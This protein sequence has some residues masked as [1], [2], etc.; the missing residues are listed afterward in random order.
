MIA[1]MAQRGVL[2]EWSEGNGMG[3]D[4]R[5]VLWQGSQTMGEFFTGLHLRQGMGNASS[6]GVKLTL[7]QLGVREDQGR[8]GSG[9]KEVWKKAFT[10]DFAAIMEAKYRITSYQSECVSSFINRSIIVQP[11]LSNCVLAQI[12]TTCIHACRLQ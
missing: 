2:A 8:P 4:G 9:R 7:D 10:H 12:L 3:W 6:N 1:F 11:H 5:R